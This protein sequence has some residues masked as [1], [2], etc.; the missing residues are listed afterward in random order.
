M[1]YVDSFMFKFPERV[2]LDDSLTYTYDLVVQTI[3]YVE[4]LQQWLPL[5]ECRAQGVLMINCFEDMM[6]EVRPKEY[7]V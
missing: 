4:A 1:R 6:L 5:V 3:I 7:C 2:V